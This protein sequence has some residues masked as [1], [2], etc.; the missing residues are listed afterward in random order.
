VIGRRFRAAPHPPAI[1]AREGEGRPFGTAVIETPSGKG[2]GGENF[3]VGSVLIRRDLRSHVHAFYRFA[4][5]ADDIADNPLLAAD[6]KIRRLDRMA[7]ILDGQPGED[8]PAAAAMRESLAMTGTTAAHCHDIL[9][10]F[11]LDAVKLRYRDWD[12]LM[13]YCRYSAAPVGRQLLDLHGEH[14]ALWPASD[15]LCAALQVLN[16]LQDCVADY[17]RLDRVY[18]PT[19]WLEAEGIDVAALAAPA[20]SPR[21]RRVLDRL[22][23][24]TEALIATAHALPPLVTAP[25]LRRETAVIV[26]LAARLAERLRRGDPL[27]GRVGLRKG[28]FLAAFLMGVFR[29]GSR[30]RRARDREGRAA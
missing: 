14:H 21:L 2:R 15:A 25:G 3:P 12:D 26:A 22:L 7:A 29:P 16:H 17:R 30:A 24:R 9:R 18:L 10:A 4:R 13:G 19:A 8:S 6:E 1:L 20:L 11:R 27:A 5:N 28:D 23:E